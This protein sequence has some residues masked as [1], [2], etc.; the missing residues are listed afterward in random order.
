MKSSYL[1][2]ID[3]SE[4]FKTIISL[5]QPKKIV[6][7]GIL[8]GFSLEHFIKYSNSLCKIEAYDIFDNFQGNH[9]IYAN[10]SEKYNIYSNV[11]IEYGDYYNMVSKFSN[12]SI[13][14]LH[15]DI[16]NNGETFK[17]AI[18]NYL[19][20]LS[21]NGVMILEGGSETRD[22]VDW[23]IAYNKSH[24]N[25]FLKE[26]KNRIDIDVNV[27][28][29]FPSITIVKKNNYFTIRELSEHDFDKGFYELINYFTRE[30]DITK[31]IVIKNNVSKFTSEFVKTFV[32][33]YENRIIG[34]GKVILEHKAHNNL[35]T[36]AHLEDLV[37]DPIYQNKKIGKLLVQYILNYCNDY[38]CYKIVLN[39]NDDII[40]FYKKLGF[41]EK[42]R[43]MCIYVTK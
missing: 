6:E 43:E 22:K 4:V 36:V 11:K 32:V 31:K 2:N 27:I 41:S 26:L 37:I 17:F 13:D 25:P 1:N 40:S 39:C 14:I 28:G 5:V 9:A 20:K 35:K 24:I 7:F 42:G 8:E 23:M 30:I 18:D 15:I 19:D 21:S 33:E 16:A 3:Y 29:D 38:N 10:I 34:T 12:G